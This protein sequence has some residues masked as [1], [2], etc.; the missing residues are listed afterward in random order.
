MKAV[1]WICNYVFWIRIREFVILTRIINSE[2]RIRIQ[3][4]K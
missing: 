3:E 2:L 4:A 1:L